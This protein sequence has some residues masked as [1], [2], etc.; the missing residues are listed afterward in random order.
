MADDSKN[1]HQV[2]TRITE[3]Q[4]KQ[5]EQLRV[6]KKYEHRSDVIRDAIEQYGV[7]LVG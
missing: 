1:N 4:I 7:C 3:E 2:F 6:S 5:L